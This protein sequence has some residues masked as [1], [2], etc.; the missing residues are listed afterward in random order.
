MKIKTA[1]NI[2]LLL[3]LVAFAVFILY[4]GW[5][6]RELDESSYGVV[7][8][9]TSGWKT[10]VYSTETFGWSFEKVI[11]ENYKMHIFTIKSNSY[12]YTHSE[13]LPSAVLYA[14]FSSIKSSDFQYK[15]TLTA[16]YSFNPQYLVSMTENGSITAE[17]F[18]EWLTGRTEEIQNILK[19]YIRERIINSELITL[20]GAC[21]AYI[22]EQYP[23]LSFSNININLEKPDMVLYN[24]AR[25]RYLQNME[26]E[27]N[28]EEEYLL[29]RLRQQN[30]ESLKLDLLRKYGEVFT[31]YP[32]MIEYL[33]I[34]REMLL[35]RATLKDLLPDSN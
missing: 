10:D 27:T 14:N 12:G 31:E 34:D 6:Q 22:T 16:S 29:E 9:K 11:P 28:A 3:I 30:N 1:F 20:E 24:R 17:S 23:Y 33:K 13:E 8:T 2:I 26:I 7:H 32:I 18:N 25:S 15:Y 19:A 35:D 4:L 5:E 21:H